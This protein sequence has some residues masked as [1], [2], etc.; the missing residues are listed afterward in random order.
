MKRDTVSCH[1]VWASALEPA[2]TGCLHLAKARDK[3]MCL[4]VNGQGAE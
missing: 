3:Q 2:C 4:A 1:E